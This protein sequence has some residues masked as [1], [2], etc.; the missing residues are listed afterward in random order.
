MMIYTLSS[1]DHNNP[2]NLNI[3]CKVFSLV[4]KNIYLHS[5]KKDVSLK[6]R[7]HASRNFKYLIT[8]KFINET[9]MGS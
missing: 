4:L 2:L 1:D 9:Y 3:T 6:T 7:M 8:Y 5:V